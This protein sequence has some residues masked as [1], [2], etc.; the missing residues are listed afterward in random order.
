MSHKEKKEK[1]KERTKGLGEIKQLYRH[2][3][4]K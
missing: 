2:K 3:D 4:C 1:V